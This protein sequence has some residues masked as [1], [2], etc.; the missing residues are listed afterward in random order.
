MFCSECGTTM[1]N[2]LTAKPNSPFNPS[3]EPFT[4]YGVF[5]GAFTCK[6]SELSQE[7]QPVGHCN[8]ESSTLDVSTI[9]DGLPKFSGLVGLSDT[10]C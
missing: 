10:V 7:F 8:C 5:P 1:I 6:M 3:D 9:H 2:P 4:M